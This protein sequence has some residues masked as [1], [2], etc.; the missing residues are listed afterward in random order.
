MKAVQTE[1]SDI[2][3][4]DSDVDFDRKDPKYEP[5]SEGL[6]SEDTGS[7]VMDAGGDGGGEI[8]SDD[9]DS[10]GR[11][12]LTGA[13]DAWTDQSEAKDVFEDDCCSLH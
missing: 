6:D 3:G 10:D 8:Y 7:I 1:G 12:E 11:Y 13:G 2:E 9:T 4:E 5:E